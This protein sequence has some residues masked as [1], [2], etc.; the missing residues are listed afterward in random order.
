MDTYKN[1]KKIPKF[2]KELELFEK[3]SNIA[4]SEEQKEAIKAIN[5]HN[6]CIITGGPGTG[7]TTIIKTMIDLYKRKWDE[8]SSM[9]ANRKS[10]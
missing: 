5:K 7:K 2:Q 4:L 6:V 9:C 3:K 10:S 1:I 8:T